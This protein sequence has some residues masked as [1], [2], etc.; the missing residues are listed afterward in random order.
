MH[1]DKIYTALSCIHVYVYTSL[2][3]T[4]TRILPL[5]N[6]VDT[7]PLLSSENMRHNYDQQ[8]FTGRPDQ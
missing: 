3:Y 1:I 8:L 6:Q 7:M 4:I 2:S 5:C